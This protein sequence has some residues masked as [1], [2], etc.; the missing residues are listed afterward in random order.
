MRAATRGSIAPQPCQAMQYKPAGPL[1]SNPA[2]QCIQTRRS[3]APQPCQAMDTNPRGHCTA[4][5]RCHCSTARR[6]QCN[7]TLRGHCDGTTQGQCTYLGVLMMALNKG[8]YPF[9]SCMAPRNTQ[10]K[11]N[12]RQM[13]CHRV[14][15]KPSSLFHAV[16]QPCSSWQLPCL[17][18]PTALAGNS[19]ARDQQLMSWASVEHMPVNML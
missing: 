2:R 14:S 6:G 3:I 9:T 4:T 7:A 8:R 13:S 5:L 1:H 19:A 16:A 18:P 17:P 11:L 15:R 12:R 10:R